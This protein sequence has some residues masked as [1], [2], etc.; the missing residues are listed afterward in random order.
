[1]L[2]ISQNKKVLVN[3]NHMDTISVTSSNIANPT[4]DAFNGDVYTRLG[5]YKNITRAKEVL[6]EIA[7][8][9]NCDYN[10]VY[11]MPEE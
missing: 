8:S 4:I 3:F 1:M 9:Y 7:N 11:Y 5:E 10:S 6:Q 2:I